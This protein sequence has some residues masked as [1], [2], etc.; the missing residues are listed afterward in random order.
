MRSG[1][2]LLPHDVSGS[3]NQP[4]AN[5]EVPYRKSRSR[6][7]AGPRRARR[8]RR[9]MPLVVL[10]QDRLSGLQSSRPW[11][12][13][14]SVVSHLALNTSGFRITFIAGSNPNRIFEWLFF[15]GHISRWKVA[16]VFD[17]FS[18]STD[19]ISRIV[20][21]IMNSA[22]AYRALIQAQA[23]NWIGERGIENVELTDRWMWEKIDAEYAKAL[24]ELMGRSSDLV[25]SRFHFEPRS[26]VQLI[27]PI[28]FRAKPVVTGS[29][30]AA[31]RFI[32]AG[33][34]VFP[35][36]PVGVIRIVGMITYTSPVYEKPR[37]FVF[38][39]AISPMRVPRLRRICSPLS[40]A[41]GVQL[42]RG[43]CRVARDR[44]DLPWRMYRVRL[45]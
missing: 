11:P 12:L 7:S 44:R 29:L 39:I 37:V 22:P 8:Q 25:G 26:K 41:R 33:L 27:E 18:D 9:K 24:V 36:H 6:R 35:P 21:R 40:K 20:L 32:P 14:G 17:S 42:L 4:K 30:E 43:L 45:E 15:R 16:R 13:I 1:I 31:P 19:E 34:Q 3:R 38:A 10:R 5:R 2:R 23:F 28:G